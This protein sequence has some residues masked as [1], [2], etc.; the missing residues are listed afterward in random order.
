[1]AGK[2]WSSS[3]RS[4]GPSS[5]TDPVAGS[6]GAT[7]GIDFG[8]ST[9]LVA[10]REGASAA[11]LLPIGEV[12]PEM[13]SVAGYSPRGRLLTGER[14]D[15]LPA[16]RAIRSVKRQISA[17]KGTVW[18]RRGDE[19][20]EVSVADVI[21]TL[22]RETGERAARRG[23]DLEAVGT[24]RLGCPAQWDAGQRRVLRQIAA[25]SGIGNASPELVDE[26]VA[27][28]VGWIVDRQAGGRPVEG[29]VLVFDYGGGTL[30]VAVLDVRPVDGRPAISVLSTVGV[31]R[32][33]D[34][35]DA[36]IVADL[37]E[38]W[39]RGGFDLASAPRPEAAQAMA[40]RAARQAKVRL[41]TA[42][43]TPVRVGEDDWW[44]P[45]VTYTRS[46]LDERF[47]PQLD[48][49]VRLVE[50]A[51]QAADLRSPAGGAEG[52]GTV[53]VAGGM[54][55]VPLVRRRLAELFPG[56]DVVT[57][58]SVASPAH[59][60]AHGLSF[61]P[62][63]DGL[64]LHRPG[65]D[66]IL[67]WTDASGESR[68]HTLYQAHTPLYDW[69]QVVAGHRRLGFDVSTRDVLVRAQGQAAVRIVGLDGVDVPLLIGRHEQESLP[70]TVTP[71][72]PMEMTLSLDGHLRLRGSDG[73]EQVLRVHRWPAFRAG[74]PRA[75]EMDM[76]SMDVEPPAEAPARETVPRDAVAAR[77]LENGTE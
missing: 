13:P 3:E 17:R 37:A 45:E 49:A 12:T 55:Q 54:S 43:T 9:T 25:E 74:S 31:H 60:V 41:S 46:R 28:G 72:R 22:L 50:A 35:L 26:P 24:L 10:L 69:Q 65:F 32:A 73:R 34:A 2:S 16:A 42:E 67:E 6:A 23:V 8:T 48:E 27:A 36:A 21:G 59:S 68:R 19:R 51:L 66:V 70:V 47:T 18:V 52:I 39:R 44:L 20:V 64:S 7:I 76:L 15:R 33:G 75:L 53:L 40:E 1:M 57:D 38:D 4:S 56:A 5:R 58:P 62:E 71:Q 11:D 63:F 61:S 29:R 30:D 77:A 14:A